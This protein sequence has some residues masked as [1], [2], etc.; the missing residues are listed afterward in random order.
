GGI[1]SE[2]AKVV[3]NITTRIAKG[4]ENLLGEFILYNNCVNMRE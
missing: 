3:N 1:G 4:L 2:I